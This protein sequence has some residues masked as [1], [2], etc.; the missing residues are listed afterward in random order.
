MMMSRELVELVGDSVHLFSCQIEKRN[1]KEKE[2]GQNGSC[3]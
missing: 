2:G 3:F 1:T